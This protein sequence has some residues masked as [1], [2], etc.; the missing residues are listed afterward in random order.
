MART[1]EH[2]LRTRLNT[3]EQERLQYAADQQGITVSELIRDF[4][5]QLPHPAN[6]RQTD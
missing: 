2:M 5:K 6:A 1:R 3:S 4:I